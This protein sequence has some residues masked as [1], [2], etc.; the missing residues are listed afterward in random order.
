MAAR[1]RQRG[2]GARLHWREVRGKAGE[3]TVAASAAAARGPR[4]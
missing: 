1:G 2:D 3:A 4:W